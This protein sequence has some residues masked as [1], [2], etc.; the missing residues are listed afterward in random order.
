MSDLHEQPCEQQCTQAA[1]TNKTQY[2]FEINTILQL[3]LE[4][5][6]LPFGFK[7][8]VLT[9]AE[10]LEVCK[11]AKRGQS[12]SS[13]ATKYG[14]GKATVH[15]DISIVDYSLLTPVLCGQRT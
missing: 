4:V 15:T 8:V 6:K 11:A 12:L 2:G 10:K 7:Y 3:C 13:L 1:H 9:I 14:I 5:F